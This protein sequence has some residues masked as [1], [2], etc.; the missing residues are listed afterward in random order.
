MVP[1]GY[2][3]MVI[4][5]EAH[6]IGS[7]RSRQTK[8]IV[9]KFENTKYKYVVTGTLNANNAM[10]FFMPFRFMGPD[11][12]REANFYE[13]RSR[14]FLAVDPDQHIWVPTGST[15]SHVQELIGNASVCFKKEDCLDLPDKVYQEY[16]CDMS[17]DQNVEYLRVLEDMMFI[18]KEG[19]ASCEK[20]GAKCDWVCE[21]AILIKNALVKNS[22]LAQ[23]TCGF[24]IETKYEVTPEGRKVDKSEA[25]FFD[26]NPKLDL[27]MSTIANI[28][29][30]KKIIIWSN[31]TAAIK[32]I[33]QRLQKAY[34]GDS[35]LLV[36]GDVDAFEAVE[37]FK[38]DPKK[39]FFVANPEKAGTGLNIQFSNY[40][41]F[42]SKNY[43]YRSRQQAEDRQHRQGQKN[44]VT[45]IDV[46]CDDTIDL[47][48]QDILKD[49][50]EL[51]KSLNTLARV[52][53][54][55]ELGKNIEHYRR[56]CN[57]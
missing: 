39:R 34:G 20:N 16:V 14:H 55:D 52:G 37:K 32:L 3:D 33:E 49:K 27:L 54:F 29:A 26:D 5:D 31:F 8:K 53:G 12:M 9:D 6:R 1:D 41:I 43:S 17:K 38:I 2:F 18:L 23:I 36:Y 51:D 46:M 11:M 42:F 21:N 35:Y 7:P 22:K 15:Y 56:I 45:V 4:A 10:S 57:H 28:P 44:V 50:M 19:C 40:Q 24:F 47:H 48:I 30:D 25:H 13:F